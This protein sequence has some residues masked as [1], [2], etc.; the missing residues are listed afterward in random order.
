MEPAPPCIG[1]G[2]V[3]WHG[4]RMKMS[5]DVSLDDD[6]VVDASYNIVYNNIV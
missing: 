6:V 2:R 3:Q 5:R 1:G 4:H